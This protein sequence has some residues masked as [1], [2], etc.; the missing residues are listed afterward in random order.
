M[1]G[2]RLDARPLRLRPPAPDGDCRRLE[3][4]VAPMDQDG[5]GRHTFAAPALRRGALFVL[6]EGAPD[7]ERAALFEGIRAALEEDR[8]TPASRLLRAVGDACRRLEAHTLHRFELAALGLT[9]L[10]IEEGTAYLTQLLPSQAFVIQEGVVRGVPDVPMRGAARVGSATGRRWEVEIDV[11]RFAARPGSTYVLCTAGLAG[12]LSPARLLDAAR[13]SA[14]DAAA[15]LLTGA[16]KHLPNG[17]EEVLV[18]RTTASSDQS[19]RARIFPLRSRRSTPPT[20][21][22]AWAS[23]GEARIETWGLRRNDRPTLLRG[24]HDPL[25]PAARQRQ[26]RALWLTVPALAAVGALLAARGSRQRGPADAHEANA[27]AP[28][29]I[30][31]TTDDASSVRTARGTTLLVASQA[32]KS[33]AVTGGVARVLDTTN[34]IFQAGASPPDVLGAMNMLALASRDSETLALDG[35]RTVWRLGEGGEASRPLA[36]RAASLWQRPIAI[37]TYS[38]NLYVLDVGVSGSGGQIWRHGAGASGGFDGDA[39]AWVAL[40]AGVNLE[41]ATSFAIDGA[42]WVARSDGAVLRLSAGRPEPFE[43]RGINVPIL[44]ASAVY[45][46]RALASVYVVDGAARRILKAT[47]SGQ[48]EAETPD[49]FPIGEHAYGLWV[50]ETGL[51]ALVLTDRRLQEV[52]L[53]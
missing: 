7:G 48:F 10:L 45:A 23:A 8:G 14:P 30:G 26:R 35:S 27:P 12:R 5:P 41:N 47:K 16:V 43:L 32:F 46:D 25:P 1:T 6:V 21:P 50:D 40:N 52:P 42:I 34:R 49:V 13:R 4:G 3:F 38:G 19:L 2:S 28:V 39:Q 33:L 18:V 53:A 37:S 29:A 44:T 31:T 9:A 22:A 51:R 36:L 17:H 15:I 24:L 11:S 20:L